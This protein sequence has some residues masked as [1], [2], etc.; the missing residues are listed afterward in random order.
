MGWR[1][2]IQGPAVMGLLAICGLGPAAEPE[3]ARYEFEQIRFAA[4]VRLAF[5]APSEP[6]ANQLAEDVFRRLKE[7][8]RIMSDYDPDS[9][10]SQLCENSGP[11]RP[12]RVSDELWAVIQASQAWSEATDGQFDISL[13]P[14]V[15]LWRIARRKQA[16]PTDEERREALAKSGW[17]SIVLDPDQQTVEL[18]KPGM[19]LDLGGIAQGYAADEA[20]R[21]LKAGGIVSAMVDVSGDICVSAPPPGTG[22][23]RIA[24]ES[25]LGPDSPE[26]ARVLLLRN[27]AVS[28]S[29]AAYQFVEIEGVRYSHIIDPAT[30][31]G[32]TAACTVTVIAPDALT[33]D[34]IDTALCLQG[35]ERGLRTVAA[36]PGIEAMFSTLID[37]RLEVVESPGFARWIAPAE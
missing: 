6:L 14:S 30:G 27:A 37:G 2:A 34:G 11:G 10:L 33:A 17:R 9:E 5:Y 16:L 1:T 18:R 28:T 4:P 12:V 8:D 23:W 24:I 26:G 36:H 32:M 19:R 3:T 7:F 21:I 15:R 13:A 29:G 35:S 31:L 22:G 25:P 20:M